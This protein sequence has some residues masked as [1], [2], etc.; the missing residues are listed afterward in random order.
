M[1]ELL[2]IG[3]IVKI[4]AVEKRFM[5][6]GRI[7]KLNDKPDTVYDYA[8]VIYPEGYINAEAVYLFNHESIQNLYYIG[9][10]DLEEFEY[11]HVLQEEIRKLSR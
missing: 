10:Q 2:P 5:I 6:I 3:S 9:M 7:Q 1:K 4:N 11:R 8:A